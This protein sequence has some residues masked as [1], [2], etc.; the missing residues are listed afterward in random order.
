MGFVLD[1]KLLIIAGALDGSSGLILS[2]IMCKA[3]NRSFTNVLFGAFGQVQAAAADDASSGKVKS[4]DGRGRGADA[5]D[6]ERGRD[7]ARATAWPWRRR[8]TRVREL[9]DAADEA[10]HRREV[11]HPPG[12]RP[13]AGAHERAAGRGRHSYDKLM[14]M[15]EINPSSP[16]ADVAIV[17]GANDV[18]NPAARTRQEQPDLRHADPQRRQGQDRDG[19]Q[20]AM[21]PGFAG[22][23]NEL[24]YAP[25]TL[26]LFGD[27]KAVIGD[28]AKQLTGEGGRH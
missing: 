15:D 14:E 28:L 21:N 8:S 27:A 2:I 20:A 7:R 5:R 1:N 25:N 11:R 17:I 24:Y 22:I 19:H 9:F 12:R 13:H 10:G 26:M 23:E 3:M 4:G 16:Q 18:V 6:A